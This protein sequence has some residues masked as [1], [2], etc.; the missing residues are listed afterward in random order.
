MR[1]PKCNTENPIEANFC[2]CCGYTISRE[3]N[4]YTEN[5]RL[6]N[7]NDSSPID[8]SFEG[9]YDI[10][11]SVITQFDMKEFGY[12]ERGHWAEGGLSER[13]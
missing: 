12:E 11:K 1:C 4:I 7:K 10:K 8:C 9:I 2:R 6:L 5:Q 3:H 13:I